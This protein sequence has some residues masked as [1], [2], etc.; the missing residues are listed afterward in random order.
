MVT[1]SSN[2]KHRKNSF[3]NDRQSCFFIDAFNNEFSR[4]LVA[5]RRWKFI[6]AVKEVKCLPHIGVI[7]GQGQI[8]H[9]A[10]FG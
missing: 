6:S 5:W 7:G 1:W 3:L 9:G 8:F 4:P 10:N 2:L